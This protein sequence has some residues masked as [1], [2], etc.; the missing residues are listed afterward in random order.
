MCRVLE[1][2]HAEW[3][4]TAARPPAH[5]ADHDGGEPGY[6]ARLVFQEGRTGSTAQR[7]GHHVGFEAK[8]GRRGRLAVVR[9]CLHLSRLPGRMHEALRVMSL[10][11][12]HAATHGPIILAR[13]IRG[14][15]ATAGGM[16]KSHTNDRSA[17]S[18]PQDT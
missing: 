15:Y 11:W 7:A 4:G 10:G 9:G 13:V 18:W 16:H 17:F 1:D 2:I 6:L 12:R 5:H 8:E 14:A 3:D